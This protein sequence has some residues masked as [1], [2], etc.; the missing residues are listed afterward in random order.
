MKALV[1]HGPGRKGPDDA[2]KPII[3][4]DGEVTCE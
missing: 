3:L 1:H 4:H 2:P